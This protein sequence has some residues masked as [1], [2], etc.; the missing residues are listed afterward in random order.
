MA[1]KTALDAINEAL[2]T[3]AAGEPDPNAG[4][5]HDEDTTV[6]AGPGS[7]DDTAPT[8]DDLESGGDDDTAGDKPPEETDGDEEPGE[9]ADPE[10]DP[11]T[12]K[13]VEK[14]PN[15]ERERNPDGTWKKV[16]AKKPD[17]VNDPIPKELKKETQE[18][19]RTL[20]DTTKTVTAERD[21]LKQNFDYMI[22]GLQAT[23]ATPEQYSETLSWLSL[24]N[25]NDP[26]QQ[27]KALELVESVAERL[28][29]LLGKERQVGDPLKAH[30]DLQ[31]A[32][33][34]G[35]LTPDYAKEI[36]RTR[37]GQQFRTELTTT[38]RTQQ[39]QVDQA[40]Q[41]ETQ[42]R[43]DLTALEDALRSVDGT[44][45]DSIKA[46]IVPILKPVMAAL[47]PAQWK[48]KFSEAYKAEKDRRAAA[49]ATRSAARPAVPANQPL[50]AGKNPA[51]GQS[52]PVSSAAE[53]MNAA[54]AS[55]QK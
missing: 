48:Q 32:V 44:E 7:T 53:A 22:G 40:K 2:G 51:G 49:K 11:K 26:A 21:E 5:P 23:G 39:Q 20:I 19:I 31:E 47:N 25:S 45:Y 36:A 41:V 8:G 46:T 34:T 1:E 42:A 50:R 55:M 17:P 10:I 12:G 54:L 4:A 27:T 16:E 9:G 38:A 29:T 15:G 43:T 6:A 33:R 28:A 37:N 35:K 14:G 30:A 18:R 3:A 13:P 52:R 24:F